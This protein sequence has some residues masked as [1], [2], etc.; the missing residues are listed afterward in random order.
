MVAWCFF[1]SLQAYVR[2]QHVLDEIFK[3][4]EVVLTE[5]KD[6]SKVRA[7]SGGSAILNEWS[8]TA[9]NIDDA[10]REPGS[11]PLLHRLCYVHS[12]VSM[13]TQICK[14]NQVECTFL[15][16]SHFPP[17]FIFSIMLFFPVTV[18][19]RYV[20]SLFAFTRGIIPVGQFSRKCAQS[21]NQ[22]WT[23]IG[24]LLDWRKVN[25]SWLVY[26]VR[27]ARSVF[28][29]AGLKWLNITGYYSTFFY[30]SR[31][32][33]MEEVSGHL[34]LFFCLDFSFSFFLKMLPWLE[35]FRWFLMAWVFCSP[36]SERYARMR[37]PRI[38]DCGCS[39]KLPTSTASFCGRIRFW[40]RSAVRTMKVMWAKRTWRSSWPIGKALPTRIPIWTLPRRLWA[41]QPRWMWTT[42]PARLRH[43]HRRRLSS[44]QVDC[45]HAI[46]LLLF[47]LSTQMCLTIGWIIGSSIPWRI[48]KMSSVVVDNIT[49]HSGDYLNV[50]LLDWLIWCLLH[51]LID[52]LIDLV[53]A[54]SI[55]WLIDLGFA[56]SIDQLIDWLLDYSVV[57]W[58]KLAILEHPLKKKFFLYLNFTMI[59]GIVRIWSFLLFRVFWRPLEIN[60]SINRSNV[61]MR[62]KIINRQKSSS[63]FVVVVSY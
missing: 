40:S 9:P 39:T 55:D 28:T 15:P 14:L 22:P 63:L 52:W 59:Q 11:T 44:S 29:G 23:F 17:T 51:L 47:S 37:G 36:I 7:E 57:D 41:L 50:R 49:P 18:S 61:A 12:Y 4:M 20:E 13:M 2:D 56:T 46:F 3:H 1:V 8:K 16:S 30:Q 42:S 53:F 33:F 25:L 19:S 45:R 27:T 58:L 34:N 32:F 31:V 43:H 10:M 26:W 5:I 21:I 35:F 38:W 62:L 48:M 54:P 60:Q 24:W 6:L